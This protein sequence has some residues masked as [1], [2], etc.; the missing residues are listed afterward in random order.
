MKDVELGEP[1][2][3]L[4]HVYLVALNENAKQAKLL[5]TITEICLKPKFLLELQKSCFTMR[6]LAQTFP[7]GPMIWKVMQRNAWSDVAS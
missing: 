1:T 3:F 6:N 4:D 7:R 5:K 2:S